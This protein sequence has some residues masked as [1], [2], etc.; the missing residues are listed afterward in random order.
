MP[1]VDVKVAGKLT[2]EQK[3]EIAGEIA[4]TLE[5]VANKPKENVYIS[6]TEFD[7]ENFAK[8]EHILSDLD[9]KSQS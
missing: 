9:K 6:F 4:A 1:Y 2:I 7:R 3:R 5:R 8:G